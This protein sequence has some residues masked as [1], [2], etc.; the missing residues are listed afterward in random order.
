MQLNNLIEGLTILRPYYDD[1]N[2]HHIGAERDQFFAYATD[3]PLL[4]KPDFE[5]MLGLGWF[6][7][8]VGGE[9][10]VTYESAT[11]WSCFT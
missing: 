4:P 1:P 6:Q 5:K 7:T 9:P 11:G 10:D 8:T 3:R 2:G